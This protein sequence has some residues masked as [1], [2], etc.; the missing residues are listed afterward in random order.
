MKARVSEV[1]RAINVSM[2]A[3]YGYIKAGKIEKW[4]DEKGNVLVDS[5]QVIAVCD[6]VL[7]LRKKAI[8]LSDKSGK[9]EWVSVHDAAKRLGISSSAV[10]YRIS[11]GSIKNVLKK[12]G[13]NLID[14]N[15]LARAIVCTGERR[16]RENSSGLAPYITY[17]DVRY[18]DSLFS[19][20]KWEEIGSDNSENIYSVVKKCKPIY[21]SDTGKAFVLRDN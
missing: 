19:D 6:R 7:A 20:D 9:A 11:R 8:D 5:D 12:D 10:Y 15:E 2:S 18:P 13:Y 17:T 4:I 3:I 1:S 14:F 16:N 21:Y